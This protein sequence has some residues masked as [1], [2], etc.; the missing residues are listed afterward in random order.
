MG[1]AIFW[2]KAGANNNNNST[3]VSG[4]SSLREVYLFV[5]Q[6]VNHLIG[7]DVHWGEVLD[8]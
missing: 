6:C 3:I 8:V 5:N 4:D 2:W 1:D 7:L